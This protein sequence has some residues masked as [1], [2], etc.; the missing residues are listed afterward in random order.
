MVNAS[1]CGSEDRGFESLHS[2][3]FLFLCRILPIRARGCR[4]AVRHRTL[5]PVCVGSNPAIPAIRPLAQQAEHLPFKQGV[6]SSNLR[7]VTTSLRTAYCSQR[8]F[9]LRMKS[10]FS[11]ISSQL[12]PKSQS[13]TLDCDFVFLIWQLIHSVQIIHAAVSIRAAACGAVMPEPGGVHIQDAEKRFAGV[14]SF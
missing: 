11:L 12:L 14:R 3:H 8:L 5:T 9:M 1:D 6:R 13:L 7:R 2:P 10:H 4:Q